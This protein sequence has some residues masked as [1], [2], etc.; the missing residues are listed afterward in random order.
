MAPHSIVLVSITN[1]NELIRHVNNFNKLSSSHVVF[2]LGGQDFSCEPNESS[3]ICL[4]ASHVTLQNGTILLGIGCN[5]RKSFYVDGHNVH[6]HKIVIKGGHDALA[7][8]PGGGVVMQS[9]E[10]HDAYHGLVVPSVYRNADWDENNA[11]H[12]ALIAYDVK[13]TGYDRCGVIVAACA[14]V[15]LIRCHVSGGIASPKGTGQSAAVHVTGPRGELLARRLVCADFNGRGVVSEDR[16]KVVLQRCTIT[17]GLSNL[18]RLEVL[19]FGS[20]AEVWYCTMSQRPI[21]HGGGM[22]SM[23]KLVSSA[24][25]SSAPLHLC[26]N[27]PRKD[28]SDRLHCMTFCVRNKIG[29]V[30]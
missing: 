7:V 13:I 10:V 1:F 18:G 16:G 9:C 21:S 17:Q 26:K 22:I 29:N 5:K 4:T 20:T 15:E 8:H 2:D 23:P 25:N 27:A 30:R 6:L 3:D 14:K 28:V 19:G 11:L 24:S 12:A